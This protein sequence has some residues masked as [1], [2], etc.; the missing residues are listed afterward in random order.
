MTGVL[1]RALLVVALPLVLLSAWWVLS[2]SS[3]SV[4]A[5]PLADIVAQL[6]TVWVD[7]GRFTADVLPSLARR[8]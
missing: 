5:P 6:K 1:R 8:P 4:Y 2:S 7:G 3:E